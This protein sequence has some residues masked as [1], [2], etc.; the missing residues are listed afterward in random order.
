MKLAKGKSAKKRGR[1]GGRVE[2]VDKETAEEEREKKKE[3]DGKKVESVSLRGCL[4]KG[5]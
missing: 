4:I 1:W 5:R 3:Y 2:R